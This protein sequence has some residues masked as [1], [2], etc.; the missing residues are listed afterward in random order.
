MIP[1]LI[2]LSSAKSG[3]YFWI[4]LKIVTIESIN[5]AGPILRKVRTPTATSSPRFGT[6][7]G[8]KNLTNFS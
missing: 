6:S 1:A 5:K 2:T 4:E 7:S 8:V 3:P